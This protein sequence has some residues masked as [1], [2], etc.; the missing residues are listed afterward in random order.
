MQEEECDGLQLL[1][2][3]FLVVYIPHKED[4]LQCNGHVSFS[5]HDHNAYGLLDRGHTFHTVQLPSYHALHK[6]ACRSALGNRAKST[7]A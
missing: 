1:E 7:V 2:S 5:K 3:A 4:E 6:S